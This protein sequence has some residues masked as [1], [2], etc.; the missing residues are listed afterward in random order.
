MPLGDSHS[1]MAQLLRGGLRIRCLGDQ[2]GDGL[3]ERVLGDVLVQRATCVAPCPI[4]VV[5]IAKHSS[6]AG[7]DKRD[8]VFYL[9]YT[10]AHLPNGLHLTHT[11]IPRIGPQP[12]QHSGVEFRERDNTMPGIDAEI[13][14]L[15][16]TGYRPLRV[17]DTLF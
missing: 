1:G 2:R 17:R 9:H 10:S 14:Q 4:E 7:K 8:F 12:L 16:P 5:W 13:A 6:P 11:P 3:A 15:G